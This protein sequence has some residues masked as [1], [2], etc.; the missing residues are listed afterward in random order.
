MNTENTACA[1]IEEAI[2]QF[3]AKGVLTEKRPYGNGH[4]NDTFLLVYELPEGGKKQ[5]ILQRMNH[6][7]FKKPI[8]LM[9]N[10]VNVTEY[11]RNIISSQGG[12]P[13]RETLN[14][15]KTRGGENYYRDSNGNYWRMF[16]FIERTV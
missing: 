3:D 11:L 5:Y 4:I 14:V 15:V 7:I 2:G 6:D 12:E 8:E 1:R 13:E 16:L 9:E 10:I